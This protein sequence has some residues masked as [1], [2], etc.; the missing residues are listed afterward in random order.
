MTAE[1]LAFS[2]PTWFLL[3][4]CA[5]AMLGA[6]YPVRMTRERTFHYPVGFVVGAAFFFLGPRGLLAVL[7][8]AG[9]GAAIPFRFVLT[10]DVGFPVRLQR[11]LASEHRERVVGM[12]VD[13]LAAVVVGAGATHAFYRWLGPGDYPISITSPRG[14][15][16]FLAVLAV[17]GASA[18]GTLEIVRR[19][20]AGRRVAEAPGAPW[21]QTLASS[22]YTLYWIMLIVTGP[23]HLAYQAIYL[24]GGPVIALSVLVFVF[25]VNTIYNLSTY[26]RD[27]LRDTLARLET[28]QRLAAI[29]EVTARIAHTTRHQLGLIGI[30][31]LKLE[32]LVASLSA[33]DAALLR[34]E[35]RKLD[36]VRTS[37]QEMLAA[38]LHQA[39]AA[40]RDAGAPTPPAA[41]PALGELV[42]RQVG[43]LGAKAVERGVTLS[44]ERKDAAA[45]GAGGAPALQHPTALAEGIF[46]VIENAVSLAN[47]KVEVRFETGPL[48]T[49]VEVLDDGPGMTPSVMARATE[50]FFTTRPEG[51]GMGLAIAR[52]T[53]EREGGRLEIANRAEGGLRVAFVLLRKR[54]RESQASR[55]G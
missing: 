1:L 13:G 28:S 31:T 25:Q 50:P 23:L 32:K 26:R 12:L 14:I 16:T 55:G 7:P 48:G 44:L 4:L 29:G 40:D 24:H 45:S 3:G 18:V 33:E 47:G 34:G 9:L 51:T 8:A 49:L 30:G 46:N 5:F 52:G 27:Q 17:W 21:L 37:L 15:V 19:L 54:G 39:P 11:E 2:C 20:R 36:D 42:A 35:L 22:E 41:A 6:L 43:M 53:I 10:L 38:G